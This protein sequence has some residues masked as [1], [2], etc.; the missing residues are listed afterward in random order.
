MATK[1]GR[2]KILLAAFSGPTMNPP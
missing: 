2:G 1:E